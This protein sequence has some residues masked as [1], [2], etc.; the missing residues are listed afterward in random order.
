MY[1]NNSWKYDKR[2]LYSSNDNYKLPSFQ[3]QRDVEI[4]NSFNNELVSGFKNDLTLY[5]PEQD[6]KLFVNLDLEA[7]STDK[8][9]FNELNK[10]IDD[11]Y[12]KNDDI[13]HNIRSGIAGVIDQVNKST[14]DTVDNLKNMFN[15]DLSSLK[16]Y[17][18]LVILFL[19]LNRI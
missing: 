2:S 8:V 13:Y 19:I 1:F 5:S 6:K 10:I 3:W 9:N 12:T 15:I 7:I 14:N 4:K 16:I 11:K 17:G 18:G